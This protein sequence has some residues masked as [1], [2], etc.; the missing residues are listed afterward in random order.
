MEDRKAGKD[1]PDRES[2]LSRTEKKKEERKRE[3]GE[4]S[5]ESFPSWSLEKSRGSILS[6]SSLED[7]LFLNL[8]PLHVHLII[9]ITLNNVIWS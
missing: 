3:E 6:F 7:L 2:L 9:E 5:C 4:T 1:Q 8:S